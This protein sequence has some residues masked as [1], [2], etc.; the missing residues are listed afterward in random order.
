MRKLIF[1]LSIII[2]LAAMII[3]ELGTEESVEEKPHKAGILM[4]GGW[5][6]SSWNEAHRLGLEKANENLALPMEYEE[7]VTPETCVAVMERMIAE[8][9]DII[10]ST[11]VSFEN[12]VKDVAMQHHDVYFLQATGISVLPNLAPY[13]GR[14]Y[15]ARYL[16]GLA[17]G[18][19][20]QTGAIGYIAVIPI[21]EVVRGIDAFTLGVRHAN[22]EATVYVKYTEDW[23]DDAAARAAAERLLQEV[24]QIDVLGMHLDTYGP[25]EAARAHGIH[26]IG[27]NSFN[28]AYEDVLLTATIWNWDILYAKYLRDAVRGRLAGGSYLLGMETGIVDLAP[29]S[30]RCGEGAAQMV[31]EAREE[32]VQGER[33]VFYGPVYDQ[34]GNLRVE[35]G[36]S[37]PDATLFETLDW[38]VEGVRLP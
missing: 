24:P 29:L 35:E 30:P 36:E 22:P 5:E 6:D 20:S 10:V 38:Y 26:A 32:L 37:L 23:S 34:A 19:S 1:V 9:C 25:L 2:C 13:M 28:K 18:A 31:S 3:M 11:S 7:N 12:G 4:V 16:A 17:A 14:M 15:Q 21:P 8:G 33:D 27:C